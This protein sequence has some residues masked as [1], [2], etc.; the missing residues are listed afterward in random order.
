MRNVIAGLAL[1]GCMFPIA[2]GAMKLASGLSEVTAPQQF[3]D[4]D[5]KPLWTLEPTRIDVASQTLDRV[6]GDVMPADLIA[7]SQGEKKE[8]LGARMSDGENSAS[9]KQSEF[10][11]AAQAWCSARYRSY[12]SQDNTYQPFSGGARKACEAPEEFSSAT[13][14]AS[15]ATQPLSSDHA[16]WCSNRYNSYRVE[17]NSYQPFSGARKKCISSI[18]HSVR[19]N[20]GDDTSNLQASIN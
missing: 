5:R 18:N 1:T 9:L 17:D 2:I 16:R 14:V 12:N 20:F 7:Q 11:V 10:S 8:V 4:A 13:Q 19:N 15:D 6:P 3:Q